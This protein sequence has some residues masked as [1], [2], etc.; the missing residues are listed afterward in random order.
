MS[1]E[2]CC[3]GVVTAAVMVLVVVRGVVGQLWLRIDP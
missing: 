2:W 3:G 1:G